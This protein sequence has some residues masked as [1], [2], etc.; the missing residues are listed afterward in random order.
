MRPG[1]ALSCRNHREY[2]A[3]ARWSMRWLLTRASWNCHGRESCCPRRS[4]LLPE[5][6]SRDRRRSLPRTATPTS[7]RRGFDREFRQLFSR[8]PNLGAACQLHLKRHRM[9]CEPGASAVPLLTGLS[10]TT[11][12]KS[13]ATGGGVLAT[14]KPG[15]D[16]LAPCSRCFRS[17]SGRT[18]R[19]A[20]PAREFRSRVVHRPGSGRL[21]FMRC[22]AA[23]RQSRRSVFELDRASS[24][25][26]GLR[27]CGPAA[28]VGGKP[29][30]QAVMALFR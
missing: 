6:L 24:I 7:A 20:Q 23:P 11:Q 13:T 25:A 1:G 3:N 5:D 21:S 10:F 12:A 28:V 9:C 29:L 27:S 14:L 4:Y 16:E 22:C 30:T 2:G 8:L 15:G 17:A 26:T 19:I 18:Q